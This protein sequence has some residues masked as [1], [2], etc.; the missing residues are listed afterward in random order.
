MPERSS[1]VAEA[2]EKA[3]ADAITVSNTILGLKID[4]GTRRSCIGNGYAASR[5]PV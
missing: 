1:A 2:A 4:V 3:G 5:D